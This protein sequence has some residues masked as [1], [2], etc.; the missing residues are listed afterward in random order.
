MTYQPYHVV[1]AMEIS[2]GGGVEVGRPDHG[3]GLDVHDE[4]AQDRESAQDIYRDDPVGLENRSVI[5]D[6]LRKSRNKL[7]SFLFVHFPEYPVHPILISLLY[8]L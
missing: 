6:D 8:A 4:D 7:L 2:V 3:E 1:Q 5:T